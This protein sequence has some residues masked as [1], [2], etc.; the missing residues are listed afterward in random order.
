MAI[1]QEPGIID[2]PVDE[3]G[4][5]ANEITKNMSSGEFFGEQTMSAD[6]FSN[7]GEI[8]IYN[9]Q[10]ESEKLGFLDRV[11]KDLQKRHKMGFEIGDAVNAGEQTFAEG[12]LQIAGKVG[13][14][15]VSDII[16]EGLISGVKAIGAITPDIILNP[17]KDA[18]TWAGHAFLNTEVGKQGL[19]AAKDGIETYQ[20]WA[21]ENPRAARNLEAVIDIALL[22]TPTKA[23]P[24]V[25]ASPTIAGKLG[26][27]LAGVVEKQV[28]TN[29]KAFIDNLIR[30]KQTTAVMEKQVSRTVEIGKGPFKKSLIEASPQEA[31]AATE[32]MKIEGI[33]AK[34]TIQGN[35]NIIKKEIS[36]EASLLESSLKT[37]D[38]PFP[39]KEFAAKLEK[40]ISELGDNP[41]IVGDAQKTA[42]KIVEKMARLTTEKPSTVSNLLKSRKELDSWIKSQKGPNI[43]DPKQEGAI[44]IALREIR[45]TTNDFIDLKAKT[46][47]VKESLKKQSNLYRALDNIAPKAAEEMDTAILRSWKNLLHVMPLRGEF[48]QTMAALFGIGGLG[49]S[50]LFAP[51]FTAIAGLAIGS[52]V[53]GKFIM[54]PSA[55]KGIAILLETTD[56]AIRA[57]KDANLVKILRADRIALLE[58]SKSSEESI[59]ENKEN[60]TDENSRQPETNEQSENP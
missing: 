16:G 2:D 52:Y 53:G 15:A 48:N 32:V 55:K 28:L 10:E 37:K 19:Q 21:V 30:P 35:Y 40:T 12:M 60:K 58:L 17:M 11:H 34:E 1:E 25:P 5:K 31:A 59:S 13:A 33:G 39:R 20:T 27:K 36:K 50:A 45:Q 51:Y 29:K 49:A 46:A 41:L 6:D 7:G 57:T 14:G 47:G 44:S 9:P 54:S 4:Q 22:V 43:F 3:A 56:K 38:V 42:Q 24:S 23:K 18:A 8:V 26:K